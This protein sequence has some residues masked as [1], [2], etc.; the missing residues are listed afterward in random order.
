MHFSAL[1]F[2]LLG[3]FVFLQNANFSHALTYWKDMT[4]NQYDGVDRAISEAINMAGRSDTRLGDPS[5]KDIATAFSIIYST[6]TSD[7]DSVG[8]V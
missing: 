3:V 1:N 2:A 8:T 6:S 7:V 5:D 4:C